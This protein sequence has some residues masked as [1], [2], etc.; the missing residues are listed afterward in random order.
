MWIFILAVA[1]CVFY[2]IRMCMWI[3][4][5]QEYCVCKLVLDCLQE[6]VGSWFS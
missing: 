6:E 2:E 1:N 5:L 3:Q 4:S